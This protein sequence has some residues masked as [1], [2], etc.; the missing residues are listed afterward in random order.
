MNCKSFLKTVLMAV[1]VA[2]SLLPSR[3]AAKIRTQRAE[4]SGPVNIDLLIVYDSRAAKWVEGRGG[5]E[6]FAASNVKKSNE[7]LA[8]TGLDSLFSFRLVGVMALKTDCGSEITTN[9][10]ENMQAAVGEF[11]DVAAKRN[12]LGADIVSLFIDTGM[13]NGVS[14]FGYSLRDDPNWNSDDFSYFE[15]AALNICAIRAVD[16][17]HT[18]THELGHNMG[19]GHSDKQAGSPGPQFFDY[20]AAYYFSSGEAHYHTIMA[21]GCDGSTSIGYTEIPYFSSPNHQYS[22]VTVGD[23]DH[24]NTRTLSRTY[25][26]VSEFREEGGTGAGHVPAVWCSSRKEALDAAYSAGKKVLLLAGYAEDPST[27]DTRDISCE[28]KTARAKLDGGY[29]LWYCNATDAKQWS[30]ASRYF[31]E[32]DDI[33]NPGVTVIDP[34]APTKAAKCASGHH[35]TAELLKL[36]DGAE[37]VPAGV[38]SVE[39]VVPDLVMGEA[40]CYVTGVVTNSRGEKVC[41]TNSATWRIV[42]GTAAVVSEGGLMRSVAGAYGPVTVEAKFD[43]WGESRMLRR[44]VDVIDAGVVT[45]LSV[46]GEDMLDLYDKDRANFTAWLQCADGS[47]RQIQA[48]WSVEGDGVKYAQMSDAGELSFSSADCSYTVYQVGTARVSAVFGPFSGRKETLIYGPGYVYVSD[49]NLNRDT[50][51]PGATVT[52]DPKYVRWWRHG[53]LENETSNFS[54]VEFGWRLQC[55]GYEERTGSGLTFTVPADAFSTDGKCFVGVTARPKRDRYYCWMDAS[56][57][58]SFSKEAPSNPGGKDDPENPSD[59]GG[60]DD[61][62]EPSNPGGEGGSGT[63]VEPAVRYVLYEAVSGVPQLGEA[64]VYDGYLH[65]DDGAVAGTLQVKVAKAKLNKKT[66]VTSSA[67]AVT[68]VPEGGKKQTLKTVLNVI[69]GETMPVSGKDGR[70]LSLTIGARGMSGKFGT[71]YRIDG[72]KNLFAAKDKGVQAEGNRILNA[73]L[74]VVNVAW[75]GGENAGAPYQT[76]SVTIAKKGKVKVSGALADG[77][78]VSASSQL[79]IGEKWCCVPVAW[80]KKGASLS[81][82]VWLPKGVGEPAVVGLGDGV[83]VGKP[84]A[85]R[86]GAVFGVDSDAMAALWR[87]RLPGTLLVDMLPAGVAISGSGAK[88]QLPPESKAIGFKLSYK[89]KD[90]SFKGSFKAFSDTGGKPKATAVSVTGVVIGGKGYGAA[91]VKK[92]GSVAATVK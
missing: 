38:E 13:E 76:F 41:V 56:L 61:P 5:I 49:A 53:V 27:L 85:V 35:S 78:K 32:L 51:W 68:I 62:E 22:G 14:G 90:G 46:E 28:A 81:F 74:G 24:D 71:S 45:K 86:N 72:A 55:S 79:I 18:L 1:L 77:T 70:W 73:W 87:G 12:E 69:T 84:G 59:P 16:H 89:A 6:E 11:K 25:L 31:D 34:L 9:I 88:W 4:K 63:H 92:V 91:T 15:R 54:D 83:A 7:A 58:C 50:L 47:R 20:S 29:V 2:F 23:A 43:I 48:K 64:S 80:A 82:A 33:Y 75:R 19:A 40:Q 67:V 39:A 52:I 42:D 26:T 65:G 10:L 21:Y 66:G 8:H 60:K 3:G 57:Q 36:L 37:T 44:T 30:E 17:G